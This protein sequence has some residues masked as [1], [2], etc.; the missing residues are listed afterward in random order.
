MQ[1]MLAHIN[2]HLGFEYRKQIEQQLG[3]SLPPQK[4]EAGEDVNMDP[5]VEAQLSP[6]LAQAAQRL[7]QQNQAQVSQQQAQQKMQ[8]P[9]VQIQMQELQ[10]QQAEQQRKVQKD[11]MDAVAKAQ[12]IQVERERIAAMQQN[13]S[14]RINVDAMKAV[15]EMKQEKRLH[16]RDMLLE[17]VKHMSQMSNEEKLRSMQERLAARQKPKGE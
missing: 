17:G 14:R 6:L 5:R 10:I 4:D 16:A 8:D 12:Q 1:S 11:Q 3:M 7:L 2:E 9:L 15:A 13:E